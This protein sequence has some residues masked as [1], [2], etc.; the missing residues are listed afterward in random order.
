MAFIKYVLVA[1]QYPKR[2][3]AMNTFQANDLE[4]TTKADN[5]P[6]AA[7]HVADFPNLI[8]VIVFSI[9]GVLIAANLMFRFPDPA[10][11]VEQFNTFAGP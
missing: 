10:L 2:I 1:G 7:H 8:V 5:R 9:I 3:T 11:T 4:L 6:K